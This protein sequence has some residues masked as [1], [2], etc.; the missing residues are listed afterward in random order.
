MIFKDELTMTPNKVVKSFKVNVNFQ[1]NGNN[2]GMVFHVP[3]GK[4]R[5]LFVF[6]CIFKI[7]FDATSH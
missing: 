7:T 4:V 6:S 5:N 1:V 3:K 2:A